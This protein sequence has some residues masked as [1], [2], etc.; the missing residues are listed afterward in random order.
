MR[1]KLA[2][3]LA[4]LSLATFLAA[5]GDDEET[6]SKEEFIEQGDAICAGLTEST[7]AVDAPETEDDLADYLTELL[8]QAEEARDEFAAL[9]PPEDGEEVHQELLDAL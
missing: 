2:V 9:S 6:L 8:G 1:T 3:V 5:C 4:L 7:Q